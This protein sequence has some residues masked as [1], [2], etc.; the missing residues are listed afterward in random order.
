MSVSTLNGQLCDFSSFQCSLRST[1]GLFTSGIMV[2]SS[3]EAENQTHPTQYTHVHNGDLKALGFFHTL[4]RLPTVNE[5][6][7]PTDDIRS[8]L[9]SSPT[10]S[11]TSMPAGENVGD[12]GVLLYETDKDLYPCVKSDKECMDQRSLSEKIRHCSAE[13]QRLARVRHA[14]YEGPASTV[15]RQELCVYETHAI[16]CLPENESQSST[17]SNNDPCD[18]CFSISALVILL[19]ANTLNYM[20]RYTIAG[21]LPVFFMKISLPLYR[22]VVIC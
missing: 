15:E 12:T 4:H 5:Q 1:I 9:R 13:D 2:V 3:S 20:D 7:E 8:S 22:H 14:S 16:K 11:S 10:E 18:T 17:S 19:L 6:M 21:K